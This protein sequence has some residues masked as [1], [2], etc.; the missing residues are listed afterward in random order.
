MR[1]ETL[2]KKIKYVLPTGEC[3]IL[4]PGVPVALPDR[5][6]QE[7]LRKAPAFIT[8][9][10]DAWTE[11]FHDPAAPIQPGSFITFRHEGRLRGGPDDGELGKIVKVVRHD[12]QWKCFTAKNLIVSESLVRSVLAVTALGEPIGAWTTKDHDLDGTTSRRTVPFPDLPP[13][14]RHEVQAR[15]GLSDAVFTALATGDGSDEVWAS[16]WKGRA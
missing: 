14:Q 11:A 13:E 3:V 5:A 1:V 7:L 16:L 8:V 9:H 6:V 2:K 15:Y 12:D 4:M 10:L